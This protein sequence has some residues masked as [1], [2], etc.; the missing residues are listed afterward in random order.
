MSLA[1]RKKSILS[2]L[3]VVGSI[4]VIAA[5]VLLNKTG[6]QFLLG[7]RAASGQVT[8][9]GTLRRMDGSSCK[10]KM[11]AA[12]TKAPYVL[13]GN[14]SLVT[15]TPVATSTPSSGKMT[16][17]GIVEAA[18]APGTT[19]APRPRA[20][21]KPDYSFTTTCRPLYAKASQAD[22]YIGEQVSVLGVIKDLS[23]YATAIRPLKKSWRPTPQS[24][25]SVPPLTP[26][27]TA[28]PLCTEQCPATSDGRLL[29]NCTPPEAD[30]TSQDSLCN[31]AGRIESCGGKSFCCPIAGGQWTTDL[32]KCRPTSTAVPTACNSVTV[33]GGTYGGIVNGKS[34][35]Y[36]S[37]GSTITLAA[38]ITPLN[39]SVNWKI[40]GF[41][42]SL[43]NGGSFSSNN[44]PTVK[45]IAPT[46]ASG[47][48]QGVEIRGDISEYPNPW[49]YCPPITFAIH[50]K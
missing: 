29:R 28:R 27:P 9:N 31:Q 33:T 50:T 24:T 1:S 4:V 17:V 38:N 19:V 5:V 26:T 23:I 32:S 46:N 8:L 10:K 47:A 20:T 34:L 7:S 11:P 37:G 40:A 35:Y 44:A 41:S 25:P 2:L 36:L 12:Y 18:P 3:T 21:A 39:A 49:I 45:Y 30:G 43:P 42:I 13:E 6:I 22:K 48:D 16:F 14:F 15:P